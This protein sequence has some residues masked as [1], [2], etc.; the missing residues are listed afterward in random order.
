MPMDLILFYGFIL[1]CALIVYKNRRTRDV[2]VITTPSGMMYSYVIGNYLQ[3]EAFNFNGLEV[4]LPASLA[5]F[6][7]DSHKD[8]KR[9]GPGAL[10]TRSQLV[11]LEGDFDKYF[12]LF[13]PP[14][15]Q[16]LVL[17]ILSPDVMET[18]I[19]SSQRFDVELSGD[20]LRI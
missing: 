13:V 8:S 3:S 4:Q 7:L 5:N 1:I 15:S 18:L 11:S 12:Q 9:K 16:I 2:G 17:S 14:K 19:K 10:Y 6:Y 20:Q